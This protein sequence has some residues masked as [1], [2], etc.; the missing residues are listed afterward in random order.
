MATHSNILAWKSH[1]QRSLAG[2]N[3][4]RHN[5]VTK[6]SDSK[7]LMLGTPQEVELSVPVTFKEDQVLHPPTSNHEFLCICEEHRICSLQHWQDRTSTG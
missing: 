4:V 5:F 3:R 1:G 2:N 7:S 6:N